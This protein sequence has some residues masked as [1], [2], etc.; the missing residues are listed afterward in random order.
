MANSR[1]EY[2]PAPGRK[3]ASRQLVFIYQESGCILAES[4]DTYRKRP[5]GPPEDEG[6]NNFIN[7]GWV[8]SLVSIFVAFAVT[9]LLQQISEWIRSR[10]GALTGTYLAF[11][12][13]YNKSN[14]LAEVV[15]CRHIGQR[16]KGNITA[17]AKF[18]LD[19]E[20]E[21]ET[22]ASAEATYGFVGRIHDRQAL[23]S[24]W[25]TSK[26]SQN[27]GTMTMVLDANGLVFRGLWCGMATDERVMSS[28]CMWIKD[29]NNRIKDASEN[30]H[31]PEALLLGRLVEDELDS[32]ANPWHKIHSRPDVGKIV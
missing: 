11:T 5:P 14:L 29:T 24:Y 13:L 4:V 30:K 8:I 10:H 22:W 1:A 15:H 21:I 6:M 12:Q 31:Y 28:P 18:S 20:G 2:R 25:G 9:P 3:P 19:R 32:T 7:N 23:I 16:L 27:G 17:R 26:A